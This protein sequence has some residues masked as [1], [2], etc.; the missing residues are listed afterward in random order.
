MAIYGIVPME[1][2]GMAGVWAL[3]SHVVEEEPRLFI[4][5]AHRELAGFLEVWPILV[6]YVAEGYPKACRWLAREGAVLAPARPIGPKGVLF[7]PFTLTKEAHR[8]A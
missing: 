5:A 3:T 8:W 6:N 4:A 7:H 1:Q 2:P